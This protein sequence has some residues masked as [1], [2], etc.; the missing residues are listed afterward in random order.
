MLACLSL[1]SKL[2]CVLQL[3]LLCISRCIMTAVDV[4]Q[5]PVKAT[6][7][8]LDLCIIGLG[9][10]ENQTTDFIIIFFLSLLVYSV[11]DREWNYAVGKLQISVYH[12]A[13]GKVHQYELFDVM[14]RYALMFVFLMCCCGNVQV[15]L[16]RASHVFSKKRLFCS[17]SA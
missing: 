10:A 17:K 13:T 9:I 6:F 15:T 5:N 7:I 8:S 1:C 14:W 3:T 11:C 16:L 2:N 12:V 4:V